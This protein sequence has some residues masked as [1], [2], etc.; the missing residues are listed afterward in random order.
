MGIEND[1][2]QPKFKSEYQKAGVNLKFTVSQM[3]NRHHQLMKKFDLTLPQFNIL[4]IL[5]GQHPQATTVNDLIDRMLDKASNASRI[6]EKLRSKGLVERNVSSID[7]RA[8]DVSISS[9]GLEVLSMIDE[10]ESEFFFGIGR[11]TLEEASMLN[12]LLDKGRG[13]SE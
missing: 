8:V 13:S 12:Q 5:R 9:K 7:R 2:K 4:R 3:D 6:V 10:I 1:I 11:L